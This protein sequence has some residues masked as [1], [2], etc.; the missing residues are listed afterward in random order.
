MELFH[1]HFKVVGMHLLILWKSKGIAILCVNVL[2]KRHK[3]SKRLLA[4]GQI[5]AAGDD[6]RIPAS[7]TH[8]YLCVRVNAHMCTCVCA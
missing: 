7:C 3:Q 4:F 8:V 6:Q 2:E 1:L 5:I